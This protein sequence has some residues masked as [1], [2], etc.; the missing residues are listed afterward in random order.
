MAQAEIRHE[1][2]PQ[3]PT[4]QRRLAVAAGSVTALVIATLI[5]G[6]LT[7][8][9][10]DACRAGAFDATLVSPLQTHC[11]SDITGLYPYYG[12]VHGNVPYLDSPV[13]YPVLIGAVMQAASW[14]VHSVAGQ[15]VPRSLLLL[16]PVWC[17]LA[18]VAARRAW[19]GQLYLAVSVPV[20]A[21]IGL[22]FMNNYW[23]G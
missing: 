21:M 19:V 12:L 1:R 2:L 11:Y 16:W 22:L 13:D 17:G 14:A 3:E 10:Q 20:A 23:A 4:G 5:G 6:A 18:V 8:L 15:S 7:F 9:H